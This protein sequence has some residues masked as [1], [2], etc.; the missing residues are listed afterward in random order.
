[1][2][3]KTTCILLLAFLAGCATPNNSVS[4]SE[5]DQK[6]EKEENIVCE[7]VYHTSSRIPKKICTT[8]AEREKREKD[9]EASRKILKDAQDKGGT[10]G[11]DISD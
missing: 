2:K 9:E 3:F 10:L 11:G 7:K 6:K 5:V 1:M 8:L 4:L